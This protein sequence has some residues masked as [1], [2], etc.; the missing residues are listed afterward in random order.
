M[1]DTTMNT[2][3]TSGNGSAGDGVAKNG[4]SVPQD[5][6]IRLLVAQVRNQDPLEPKD[7]SEFVSQL[8]TLSQTEA[9]QTLVS[10][11]NGTAAML[12]SMQVLSLGGQVGNTVAVRTSR[13]DMEGKPVSGSF[14]LDASTQT[15]AVV[16]TG[17]DGSKHRVELGPRAAGPVDFTVD[18]AALGLPDG[19]YTIAVDAGEGITA[20]GID[21]RGVL[22]GIRLSPTGGVQMKVAGI[23]EVTP[24]DITGFF[25]RETAS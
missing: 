11:N 17:A 22:T 14:V 2:G 7:P 5:M 18:P 1:L 3:V 25:G 4:M 6:F 8:A 21:V 13:I 23:G 20:P 10:Q 15:A 16:L 19:K 24:A 9:L 12:D